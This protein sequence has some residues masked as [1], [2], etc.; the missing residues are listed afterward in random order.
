MWQIKENLDPAYEKRINGFMSTI[1]EMEIPLHGFMVIKDNELWTEKTFGI[2]TPDTLH[3]MFSA[4][5]S[6][7]A[8]GIGCLAG[9]GK[10]SLDDKICS[11]F[12]EYIPEEG[13]HEYLEQLTIR[14][15]LSMTTCYAGPTYRY[16]ENW[17]KSFFVAPPNH[18]PGA[19]F[20]YDTSASLVLGALVEKLSGK[21][22]LDYLREKGLAD[23]GFSKEAYIKEIPTGGVSDCGSGLM[24]SMRD[25]ARAITVCANGGAYNG[26]QIIPAEF[27]ADLGKK[28]IPNDLQ[29][30]S[31]ERHGYGYFFWKTRHDGYCMYGLGGQLAVHF[32][33]ENLIFVSIGDTKENV[34]GIQLLWRAFYDYIYSYFN[35]EKIEA[36]CFA[37]ARGE[38]KTST[39]EKISGKKFICQENG[40]GILN[41]TLDTERNVFFYEDGNGIHSIPFGRNSWTPHAFPG[42]EIKTISSGNWIAESNFAIKSYL[43]EYDLSHVFIEVSVRGEDA[44]LRMRASGEPFLWQFKGKFALGKMEN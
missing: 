1:N 39:D 2:Y 18:M 24:C 7:A 19:I 28:H 34:A 5:K 6:F 12:P 20:N 29:D 27:V 36:T 43:L 15:M 23:T 8:L 10:L 17:V 22:V 9:E 25:L 26:K 21:R 11:Y 33:K 3:R 31:E 44:V 16:D 13:V 35:D 38:L 42:T 32:P 4:A 37:P 14:Q 41:F 30:N 40:S